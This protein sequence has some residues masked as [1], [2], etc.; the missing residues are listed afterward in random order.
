M[1]GQSKFYI[2]GPGVIGGRFTILDNANVGIGKTSPI[3]KLDVDGTISATTITGGT[4]IS[5]TSITGST[6]VIYGG[7][8]I[9]TGYYTG[10]TFTCKMTA[11]F[12]QSV[13]ISR[14]LACTMTS[15]NNSGTDYVGVAINTNQRQSY[16]TVLYIIYGSFT[17][18]H[19]CF[20]N[21][22]LYNNDNQQ[23]FKDIKIGRIV[24]ASGKIATDTKNNNNMEY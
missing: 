3:Y 20:K 6:L 10:S 12:E 24:I 21:D 11:Y 9:G 16:N 8:N 15:V 18:I 7:V 1:G 2:D 17:G 14:Y 5:N 4:L 13:I 19:R 23:L 22:E